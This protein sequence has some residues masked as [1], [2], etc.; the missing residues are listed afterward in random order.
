MTV[1]LIV[2]TLILLKMLAIVMI[3][4][5]TSLPFPVVIY[6]RTYIG[7]VVAD[8]SHMYILMHISFVIYV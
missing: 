1:I 2:V 7:H 5:I 3:V 8:R 4:M 6:I